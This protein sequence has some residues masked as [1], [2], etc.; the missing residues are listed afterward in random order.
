[1][2]VLRRFVEQ[3]DQGHVQTLDLAIGLEMIRGGHDAVNVVTGT[4][5]VEGVRDYLRATVS[6]EKFGFTKA[7][8][9]INPNEVVHWISCV[10]GEGPRVEYLMAVIGDRLPLLV[11]ELVP[12]H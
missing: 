7:G 9:D 11:S 6:N 1:M 10:L 4:V 8:D 12:Q 5:G 3:L 2:V